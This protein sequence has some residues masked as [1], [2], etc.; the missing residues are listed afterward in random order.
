MMTTLDHPPE[1][2]LAL[3][4]SELRTVVIKSGNELIALVQGSFSKLL[5]VCFIY[6]KRVPSV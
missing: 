5:R 4:F 6:L 2:E 3:T 1:R